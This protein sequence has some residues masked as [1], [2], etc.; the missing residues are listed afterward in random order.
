MVSVSSV[1]FVRC[2]HS[3][4]VILVNVATCY[5]SHTLTIPSA[6]GLYSFLCLIKCRPSKCVQLTVIQNEHFLFFSSLHKHFCI[7]FSDNFSS[8]ENVI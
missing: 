6:D 4:A 5:I 8:T 7:S 3:M 1:D 2:C